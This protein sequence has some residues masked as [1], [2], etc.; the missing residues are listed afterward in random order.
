MVRNI[1][2][3][4]A[5]G[6]IGR[7]LSRALIERGDRVTVFSRHPETAR[8]RVPGAVAYVRWSLDDGDWG[9]VRVVEGADAVV[10]LAGEDLFAGG[11]LTEVRLTAGAEGRVIGTRRLV[12]SL[13]EACARV[14]S[15]SAPRMFVNASSTGIYGFTNLSNEEVTEN[16]PIPRADLWSRDT[17]R[18]EVEAYRAESFGVRAVALRIGV[19]LGRE[20][21]TLAAQVPQFR[22]GW[23]GPTPPGNQW[24]PWIHIADVV[25]LVLFVLDRR[26]VHGPLNAAAP[27]IVTNAAYAAAL[28]KVLNVEANTMPTPEALRARLGLVADLVMHMRRVVPKRAL[29]LGYQFQ[30]PTLALALEDIL[31][32]GPSS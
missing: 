18:A 16:T 15:T 30:F 20:G 24:F 17:E 1:I 6:M 8:E 28:A 5:T 12:D 4:G 21:G 10:N 14:P 2:V 26:H 22:S 23:G 31:G 27:G 29:Q 11:P 19:V 3:T 32:G 9:W 25:G 7:P 13:A